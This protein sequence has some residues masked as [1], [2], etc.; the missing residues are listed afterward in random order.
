MAAITLYAF[1][2]M[3]LGLGGNSRLSWVNISPTNRVGVIGKG[4]MCT[5]HSDWLWHATTFT[6]SYT[7]D[8]KSLTHFCP[9][10]C[11]VCGPKMNC[12][13]AKTSAETY[14]SIEKKC[15]EWNVWE[16]WNMWEKYRSHSKNTGNKNPSNSVL[17]FGHEK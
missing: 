12:S 4:C 16:I 17:P 15:V 11:H 6:K 7:Q 10:L 3:Y 5:G 13:S 8:R 9:F 1:G 2:E 14:I